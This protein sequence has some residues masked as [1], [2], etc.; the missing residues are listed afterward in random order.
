MSKRLSFELNGE[1]RVEQKDA[2]D[3][4]DFFGR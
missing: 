4:P 2:L 3:I 1:G